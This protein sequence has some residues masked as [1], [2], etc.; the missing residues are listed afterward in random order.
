M[1]FLDVLAFPVLGTT[2]PSSRYN[3]SQFSVQ[4]TLNLIVSIF[5]INEI[6]DKNLWLRFVEDVLLMGTSVF[7]ILYVLEMKTVELK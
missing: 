3:R 4:L 1:A 7:A 6:Y 2:V 5:I